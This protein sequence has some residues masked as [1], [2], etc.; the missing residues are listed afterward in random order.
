MVKFQP[1]VEAMI[2]SK[3]Q[4]DGGPTIANESLQQPCDEIT[5][6]PSTQCP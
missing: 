6:I 1:L 2:C 5:R 4:Q 3:G